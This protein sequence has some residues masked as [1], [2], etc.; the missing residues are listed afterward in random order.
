MPKCSVKVMRSYDYCHFEV[1]LGSDEN[2]TLQQIDDLR[3]DAARLADK[4][5]RQYKIAKGRAFE[6]A[7]HSA[8]RLELEFIVRAIKENIPKSEWSPE[9]KATVKALDDWNYEPYDYQDDWT[10]SGEGGDKFG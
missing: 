7:R 6:D 2:L 3:K 8:T 10:D 4:A 5:V 9:D 1:C